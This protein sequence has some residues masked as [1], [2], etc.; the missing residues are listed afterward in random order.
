MIALIKLQKTPYLSE[1]HLSNPQVKEKDSFN[2]KKKP[3]YICIYIWIFNLHKRNYD[4]FII[5]HSTYIPYFY[6]YFPMLV[7]KLFSFLNDYK[8]TILFSNSLTDFNSWLLKHHW[9]KHSWTYT[10]KM[11][12]P[13]E[14]IKSG[15][16]WPKF[17]HLRFSFI[18][19]LSQ[20]NSANLCSDQ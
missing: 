3:C 2:L 10:F 4:L 19:K 1:R 9:R 7:H 12:Y 18:A 16:S 11:L 6:Y 13:E 17:K 15:I 8:A 20:E 5:L 14:I